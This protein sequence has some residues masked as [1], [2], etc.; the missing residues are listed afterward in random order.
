MAKNNAKR[1]NKRQ[2]V[3]N[4]FP[5]HFFFFVGISTSLSLLTLFQRLLMHKKLTHISIKY[6][7]SYLRLFKQRNKSI[8]TPTEK[9]FF[10]N[11]KVL[12][13]KVDSSMKIKSNRFINVPAGEQFKLTI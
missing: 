3:G 13:T 11:N 7:Y 8:E 5:L 10:M 9:P 4:V 6:T 12:Y 2:V 1:T